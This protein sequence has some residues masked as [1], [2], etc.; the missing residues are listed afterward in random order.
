M[1]FRGYRRA[2]ASYKPLP[3]IAR[4][5]SALCTAAAM[6]LAWQLPCLAGQADDNS[7]GPGHLKD[8]V[9]CQFKA[10]EEARW[11]NAENAA[12]VKSR[13]AALSQIQSLPNQ[14]KLQQLQREV[15]KAQ[16]PVQLT[17]AI[18]SLPDTNSRDLVQSSANAASNAAL[19]QEQLK[20]PDDLLCS[21]SLLSWNEASDIFGR[22]IANTYLVVQVVVRNLSQSSDYLIQDVIVAAPDTGF[23]S[24]RDKLLA[25]GV[26]IVGQSLDPRNQVMSALDTLA[27]TSAAV[28]LIGTQGA[29]V[30]GNFMNLQNANNVLTAFIPPLKRWF[31]DYTVDQLNRLNDLAFSAST[32]YK[33]I[34]P[35]GGSAPFVTFVP[36]QLF[37]K[38]VHKWTQ[39]EFVVNENN[40]FV[41][42]AGV[43]IQEVPGPSIGT[44]SPTSGAKGT[45]VTINGTN[46]GASQGSG[47]VKFGS[48]SQNVTSWSAS[49]IVVTVP[50]SVPVGPTT[51]VVS[52][53]GKDSAPAN[54]TVTCPDAGPCITNVSPPSGSRSTLVTIS[55]QN[56]GT[57]VGTVKFGATHALA[58]PAA[59]WTDKSITGVTVP[60]VPVAPTNVVV[61]AGGKDS[62]PAIFTVNCPTAPTPC[63]M[64]LSAKTAPAGTA[65]TISGT[66]F[67]AAGSVKFG[68][69]SAPVAAG[70]WGPTTITVNVPPGLTSGQENDVVVTVGGQNSPPAPFTAQ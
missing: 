15:L 55:G 49:A 53:G 44:L 36:H 22:R 68:S 12:F 58:V 65:I 66:N 31:P 1:R 60:D 6:I 30:S 57:A 38:P 52:A 4:V 18:N 61:T 43:H 69:T 45:A 32:T 46:F 70:A 40:T 10:T 64:S 33:M 42:V 29:M 23:G 14:K 67:G 25:R 59:N 26:S 47:S 11:K 9:S 50:D 19:A 37:P 62:P 41:L 54:F 34:V 5:S 63:I 24:G 35:K 16:T 3:T 48:V 28:A 17:A 2:S 51:V 7:S 39:P 56:F 20:T 8:Y 21:R 13:L 27:T